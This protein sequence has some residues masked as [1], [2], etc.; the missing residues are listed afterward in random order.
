M[1]MLTSCGR[2]PERSC[3]KAIY[4]QRRAS[5]RRKESPPGHGWPDNFA[6][7]H[8]RE[9]RWRWNGYRLQ[10]RDTRLDRF[11]ALKFLPNNVGVGL[12]LL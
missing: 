5:M 3:D 1:V 11:V 10:G 7:P 4:R 6:L 8:P 12:L 2:Q 9:A